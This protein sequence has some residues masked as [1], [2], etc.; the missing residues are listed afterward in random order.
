[1][2]GAVLLAAGMVCL[3][4][5]LWIRA[6]VVLN[7]SPSM[8]MGWYWR[9]EADTVRV[10]M[11]VEMSMPEAY[12]PYLMQYPVGMRSHLLKR[13]EGLPGETICWTATHMRT[14]RCEVLRVRD[15]AL[16]AGV[17]G[18]RVLGPEEMI[19]V[20]THARSYDSRDIGAV[21]MRR[22]LY[23]LTPLWTWKGS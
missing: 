1:M 17:S 15:R 14:P 22:V 4:G 21:D 2:R 3:S 8:P 23:R 13:V 9:H 7:G 5:G 20:G 18:C 11:I 6:H 16:G 12:V 19:V 10:G